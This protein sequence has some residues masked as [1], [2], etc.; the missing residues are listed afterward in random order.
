[1]KGFLQ[2]LLIASV[3][4]SISIFGCSGSEE[5]CEDHHFDNIRLASNSRMDLDDYIHWNQGRKTLT[6]Y[7]DDNFDDHVK[8]K[9]V[10][11]DGK[12][13]KLY[14]DGRRLS[15]SE[16]EENEDY[17]YDKLEEIEESMKDLQVDLDDLED[18]LADLDFNFD[19]NF[20]FDDE[21]FRMNMS[22]DEDAFAESME[23]LS[24]ALS[25]LK[26]Q[27]YHFK[28]DDDDWDWSD[29]DSDDWD[30][31]KFK[32]EMEKLKRELSKLEDIEIDIDMDDFNDSMEELNESLKNL[33][34][35][36]SGFDDEMVKLNI[37]MK[38]LKK[39]LQKLK[40]FLKDM[41]SELEW[42]G[43]IDDAG[44]DFELELNEDEMIVNGTRLPDKLH[45]KYLKMYE[46]HF[47]KK[48]EDS[49]TMHR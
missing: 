44:D 7:D 39:D 36:M 30:S 45:Q 27:N 42:D 33:K 9:V 49:F 8:W 41:S 4:M 29:H 10:L 22:F 17:I 21:N 48:L 18:E 3:L 14:K 32:K 13:E 2:I 6:F 19:F 34:I 25:K 47:G 15:E 37:E 12:I 24:K 11:D 46:K 16:I 31:K 40:S 43:Y 38:G 26:G 1:M 35:N 5:T 28:F 23:Q 20:D